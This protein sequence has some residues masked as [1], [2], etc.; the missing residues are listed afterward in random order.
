MQA[1]IPHKV[2]LCFFALVML[3]GSSAICLGGNLTSEGAGQKS[4]NT[5]QLTTIDGREKAQ[6]SVNALSLEIQELKKSVIKLNK[7]LRVLQEDLLFPP[8]TQLTVFLSMDV[9]K[10][11]ELE[12]VRLK[13]D[14]NEV[15]S[16][17]YTNKELFAL[18]RGGT[19]RLHI[20]NLG[21]GS[22]TL[23]AFFSGSGPSGRE[24]KRGTTL[25]F[26][27]KSGAKY[28]ELKI[29]DSTMKLQPVF[30]VAQW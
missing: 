28:V 1:N 12:S 4:E 26:E 10:F 15:A 13:I 7:N 25:K 9:G 30:S 6:E 5:R 23:S 29:T 14:G 11:F 22:H 21:I 3:A 27:K 19:Q 17:I 18:S 24:Y 16:H 20:T 8:N 2:L